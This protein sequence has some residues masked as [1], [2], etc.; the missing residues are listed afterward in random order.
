MPNETNVVD[1]PP[2][3][4]S[5]AEHITPIEDDAEKVQRTKKSKKTKRKHSDRPSRSVHELSDSHSENSAEFAGFNSSFMPV[6]EPKQKKKKSSSK[7]NRDQA[8]GSQMPMSP[9]WPFQF[10]PADTESVCSMQNTT[11]TRPTTPMPDSDE[12]SEDGHEE[13][14]MINAP[15]SPF[16]AQN[17]TVSLNDFMNVLNADQ[18]V[19]PNVWPNVAALVEK[20]WNM[21]HKEDIK[22]IYTN[23]KRPGNTP[24]LQKVTLDSEI[25]AG[26][27]ERF[28]AA[29]RND[30][31]LSFV[32]N[33]LVK[34][35]IC[36]TEILHT[37][38]TQMPAEQ[39]VKLTLS[40]TFDALRILSYANSHL[41]NTR[42]NLIK[43]ALDPN[44]RQPLC[45][46]ATLEST[47]TSH[48]LFGGDMHKQAK[49]GWYYS[50]IP[51]ISKNPRFQ[52]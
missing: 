43:F 35:A 46:N 52:I 32:S 30:A 33:A 7:A 10:G 21:P 48:Q 25:A 5:L 11:V 38:M 12:E 40:K 45:K 20:S 2:A 19:G 15:S 37:N 1:D 26:L 23:H 49:E 4:L 41:H 36:L 47:N 16:E 51:K 27:A 24:S 44:L 28:P 13:V 14:Q 18:D 22:S 17:N 39:I 3:I 50:Y 9:G 8:T 34:S 31:S 42:R 6:F 29:K